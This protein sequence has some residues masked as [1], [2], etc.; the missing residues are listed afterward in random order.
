[1]RESVLLSE[2]QQHRK[3][4]QASDHLRYPRPRLRDFARFIHHE[5]F[6]VC[7]GRRTGVDRKNSQ[8]RAN[9]ILLEIEGAAVAPADDPMLLIHTDDAQIIGGCTSNIAYKPETVI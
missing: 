5:I 8:H 3:V 2:Q 4:A 7:R 9:R 6:L 1:M